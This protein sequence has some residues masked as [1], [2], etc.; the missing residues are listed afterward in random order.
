MVKPSQHW[1]SPEGDEPTRTIEEFRFTPPAA[2]QTGERVT[3]ATRP[4]S[5]LHLRPY[6]ARYASRTFGSASSAA[7][8]PSFTTWP[9][10]ST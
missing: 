9:F 4:Q 8:V 10:S 1:G 2:P 7:P 5:D 6:S 3:P